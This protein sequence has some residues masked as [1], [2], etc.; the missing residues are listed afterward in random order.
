MATGSTDGLWRQALNAN[1]ANYRTVTVHLERGFPLLVADDVNAARVRWAGKPRRKANGLGKEFSAIADPEQPSALAGGIRFCETVR[2]SKQIDPGVTIPAVTRY[3]YLQ[4]GQDWRI[5][6]DQAQ[7]RGQCDLVPPVIETPPP[8]LLMRAAQI[9]GSCF[10]SIYR[11]KLVSR[12]RN[13]T[14]SL[15]ASMCKLVGYGMPTGAGVSTGIVWNRRDVL[16]DPSIFPS[17]FVIR[18]WYSGSP[19]SWAGFASQVREEAETLRT[20]ISTGLYGLFVGGCV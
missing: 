2:L 3:M 12:A 9:N 1:S 15:S 6:S 18:K 14:A 8:P 11:P 10:R 13:W 7:V 17:L 5:H 16:M 20:S 19:D 4:R